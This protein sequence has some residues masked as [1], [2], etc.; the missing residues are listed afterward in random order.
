MVRRTHMRK[1]RRTEDVLNDGNIRRNSR[2][3]TAV[4]VE[5]ADAAVAAARES[6]RRRFHRPGSGRE[7]RQT[8]EPQRRNRPPVSC[9]ASGRPTPVDLSGDTWRPE[10]RDSRFMPAGRPPYRVKLASSIGT[11]LPWEARSELEGLL[12]ISRD[13]KESVI[14]KI[15]G[16]HELALRLRSPARL[17]HG[18]SGKER[19]GQ[20]KR[21]AAEKRIAKI[22]KENLDRILQIENKIDKMAGEV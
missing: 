12:N 13:V 3:Q 9:L 15:G 4:E 5:P 8:G 2:R 6:D 11:P 20:E 16:D 19:E 21:E 18:A 17:R 7:T 22:A 1:G 10:P 14:G